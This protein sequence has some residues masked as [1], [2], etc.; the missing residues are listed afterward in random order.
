M[1]AGASGVKV[2]LRRD[3][4]RGVAVA[5]RIDSRG[6]D[7]AGGRAGTRVVSG[8]GRDGGGGGG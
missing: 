3:G 7:C 5:E 4:R 1:V 6:G 2:P 8:D